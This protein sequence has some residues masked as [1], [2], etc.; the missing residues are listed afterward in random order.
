VRSELRLSAAVFALDEFASCLFPKLSSRI[1][2]KRQEVLQEFFP[3][4][5]LVF[6]GVFTKNRVQE[7]VFWWLICGGTL[8]DDG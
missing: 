8:V 6:E 3:E 5:G 7:V 1:S 2:S 4:G